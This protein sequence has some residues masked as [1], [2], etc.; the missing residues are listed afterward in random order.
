M[1]IGCFMSSKSTW[2]SGLKQLQAA[3]PDHEII[4][5]GDA[6]RA[7]L[8]RLDAILSSRLDRAEYAAATS[9]KAVFVPFTGLNH[10]P[11]ELLLERGVRV[12][13]VHGNAE[14][15]AQCAIAMTLAFYGRGIEF[16]NDLREGRWHGF[17]VGRGS[18]DEWSSIYRRSCAVFGVGAIG[19]AL[20]RILK[21]FDCPV[22]GCRRRSD[23]PQPPYFDR[24]ESDPRA[25]VDGADV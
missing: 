22:V 16:H 17:W 4:V 25:A 19:T 2:P 11:A 20:A 21:A 9:L 7:A 23:L 14:S 24:I 8:P 10:L 13:N 18:E 12:F 5:G 1:T 3:F 15:V 6:G